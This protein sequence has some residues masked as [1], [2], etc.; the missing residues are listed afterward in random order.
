MAKEPRAGRV[1]TRLGKDIGT[2]SA[3]WWFRHKAKA[4][5]RKL[6]DPRW[7]LSLAISPDVAALNSRFWPQHIFR[8]GQGRGD[9]GHRMAKILDQGPPGPVCIIG[10][11][12]PSISK[13]YINMRLRCTISFESNTVEVISFSSSSSIAS[14]GPPIL[15]FSPPP[16]IPPPKL[17]PP[18]RTAPPPKRLPK[19][20]LDLKVLGL[21]LAVMAVVA[22]V[23][24]GIAVAVACV[25][26]EVEVVVE[27]ESDEDDDEEVE[28]AAA[29]DVAT[30]EDVIEEV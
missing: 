12:I 22:A 2:V 17:L 9:L 7:T 8:V 14:S 26:I 6:E 1:K 16:P 21:L 20:P 24:V 15:Q 18:K 25:S 11:D 19:R 27:V 10:S 28:E 3:A 13:N 5:I 23:T 30:A 29:E 4:L